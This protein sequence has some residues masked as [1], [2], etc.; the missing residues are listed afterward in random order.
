L[1]IE[2]DVLDALREPRIAERCQ[3]FKD[4]DGFMVACGKTHPCPFLADG[5]CG[6]Y[7]TRPNVC[8]AFEPGEEQCDMAREM[9]GLPPYRE[10]AKAQGGLPGDVT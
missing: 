3:A 5:K 6:I 2:A 1:I 10:A 9:A 7:P 8:V 4:S